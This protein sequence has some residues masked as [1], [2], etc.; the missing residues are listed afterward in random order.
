MIPA[1]L[2]VLRKKRLAIGLP[3]VAMS[4]AFYAYAILVSGDF[5]AMGRFLAPGWMFT[6]LLMAW[7]LSDI[8]GTSRVRL[9]AA[10]PVA[11]GIITIGILPAFDKHIVPHGFRQRF[12]FRGNQKQEF[13]RSEYR[14]WHFQRVNAI[15]WCVRGRAMKR[16]LPE[17]AQFVN[18]GIGATAYYSELYIHD[19]NGLVNHEVA[20]MRADDSHMRSPGHDKTVGIHFF[21]KHNP[22]VIR[23]GIVKGLLMTEHGMS[24]REAREYFWSVLMGWRKELIE[25]F[26]LH[27]DYV[28]DFRPVPDWEVG[29]KYQYILMWRRIPDHVAPAAAWAEFKRRADLY[30]Q[31]IDENRKIME[32]GYPGSPLSEG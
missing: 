11:A 21:L 27:N 9:A 7:M 32:E 18:G 16:W 5:M 28:V 31:G 13:F 3:I 25:R 30:V 20:I 2:V 1:S 10:L 4:F 6:T 29:G 12:H 8:A 17:D 23:A 14:Q 15:K 19:R 26:A 24:E 22:D